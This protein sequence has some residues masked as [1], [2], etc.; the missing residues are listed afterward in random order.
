MNGVHDMGGMDGFGP[1]FPGDGKPDPNAPEV[2]APWESRVL[3]LTLAVGSL[4]RWSLDASRFARES[5]PGPEYLRMSYYKR[6]FA[7]LER[8]I[9]EHGILDAA[10]LTPLKGEAVPAVLASGSPSVRPGPAPRFAMGDKVRVRNLQPAGHTRLPA[11]LRGHVGE[12]MRLHG[13]HLLPDARAEGRDEPQPLY[14]VRFDAAEVF[15]T[16]A[17]TPALLHADLFEPYLDAP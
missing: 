2:H 10:G 7:A 17:Q 11:Y 3:A 13:C 16:R 6:W 12:V 14:Q 5:I 1:I 8:Q 4:R 9:A 15:G